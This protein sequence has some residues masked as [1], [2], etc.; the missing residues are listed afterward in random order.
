VDDRAFEMTAIRVDPRVQA[1]SGDPRF[2][3][4]VKRLGVD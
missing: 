3:D 4:I 2:A 1:V